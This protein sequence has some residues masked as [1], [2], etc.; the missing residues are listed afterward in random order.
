MRYA[1][2]RGV[3]LSGKEYVQD[4]NPLVDE[5][6]HGGRTLMGSLG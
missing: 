6:A 4:F 5:F 2:C 1:E 3:A